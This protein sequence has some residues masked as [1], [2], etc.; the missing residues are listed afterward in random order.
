MRNWFKTGTSSGKAEVYAEEQVCEQR[1]AM[2]VARARTQPWN[3][4]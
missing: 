1:E 2:P 4:D 3:V